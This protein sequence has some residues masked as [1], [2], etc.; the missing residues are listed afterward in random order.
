MSLRYGLKHFFSLVQRNDDGTIV[1][2]T[3]RDNPEWSQGTRGSLV[4]FDDTHYNEEVAATAERALKTLFP[5]EK[6]RPGRHGEG[7]DHYWTGIIA[8]T[9]DSVPMVGAIEGKEGQWINAGH[10][11]HGMAR[12]WT[13]SPGLAKLIVGEPWSA[14]GLPECFQYSDARLEGAVKKEVKSVW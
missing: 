7:T 10:N 8:M 12:I 3:S 6:S 5:E 4:T 1:F 11:G 13:C 9:P 14:T 2:G